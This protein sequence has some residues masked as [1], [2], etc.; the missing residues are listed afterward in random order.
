MDRVDHAL[1]LRD[2]GTR[3]RKIEDGEEAS[4]SA[5]PSTVLHICGPGFPNC[6][7]VTDMTSGI[8]F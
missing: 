2:G 5:H 6:F 1:V 7:A 8:D 3:G 4:D